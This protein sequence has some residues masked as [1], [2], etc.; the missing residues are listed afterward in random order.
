MHYPHSVSA[1]PE[2]SHNTQGIIFT[3]STTT[4]LLEHVSSSMTALSMPMTAM[5]SPDLSLAHGRTWSTPAS[6]VC[7][8][9]SPTC[10]YGQKTLI[11]KFRRC[12]RMAMLNNG[13]PPIEL[14]SLC[15]TRCKITSDLTRIAFSCWATRPSCLTNLK[16]KPE[17]F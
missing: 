15:D 11:L 3:V 9:L 7:L 13:G 10:R 14:P 8:L 4:V 1:L 16:L 2:L 6:E 12:F 5:S 17:A